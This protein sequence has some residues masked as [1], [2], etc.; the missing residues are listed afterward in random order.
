MKVSELIDELKKYPAETRVLTF[1]QKACSFAEPVISFDD[2]IAVTEFGAE[3]I[4]E[5]SKKWQYS[6]AAPLKVLTIR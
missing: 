3:K 1:D 6:S 5:P 4:C 2:M